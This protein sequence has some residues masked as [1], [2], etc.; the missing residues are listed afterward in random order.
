MGRIAIVIGLL[1]AFSLKGQDPL[2]S[3]YFMTPV[4]L[5]PAFAGV[6]ESPFLA[7]NY[8]LQW[9]GITTT[10]ST[11]SLT[12]D[13]F[14]E[15]SNLALGA[16]ILSDAAGEGALRTTKAAGIL[17]YR[18]ALNRNT[19][20]RGGLE[21]SYVQ[22]RLNWEKFIFYDGLQANNGPYTPGGSSIPSKE[23]AP[24]NLR[25]GYLDISS[26]LLLY[27]PKYFAGVSFDHMNTPLDDFLQND[28][29]NYKGLP[30][31]MTWILGYK[32]SSGKK[33][34][35]KNELFV[36]PSV[37]W[38]RQAGFSQANLGA[39]FGLSGF[40]GGVFYRMAGST[41]DAVIFNLGLRNGNFKIGYSYDVTTSGLGLNESGG[42]HEIGISH[43]FGDG[44]PKSIMNDC[45]NLFR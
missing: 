14:F 29:Q 39:Y 40:F 4:Q 23:T 21:L 1:Y 35:D 25:R 31:R 16:H 8:R 41:P 10:Y 32:F 43:I 34:S 38:A 19:Y 15:T 3:Q 17:A 44:K 2:Y 33:K 18:L 13:Q 30:I 22:R 11:F 9:P 20:I 45:I 24:S 28:E 5:N 12:Y 27:H 6:A 42:S 7:C 37:L 36:T 26:G